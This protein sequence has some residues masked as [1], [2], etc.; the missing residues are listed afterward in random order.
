MDNM[1]PRNQLS[2][3]EALL[4]RLKDMKESREATKRRI[5]RFFL[6]LAAEGKTSFSFGEWKCFFNMSKSACAGDIRSALRMG[7]IEHRTKRR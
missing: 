1:Q 6:S 3:S 4:N 2:L 7:L 5:A